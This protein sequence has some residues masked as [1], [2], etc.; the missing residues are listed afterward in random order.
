MSVE[1]FYQRGREG[2]HLHLFVCYPCLMSSCPWRGTGREGTEIPG[3][4]GERWGELYLMLHRHN[5]ND[6]ALTD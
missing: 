5:Q 6:C 3:G 4:G 2:G 1:H